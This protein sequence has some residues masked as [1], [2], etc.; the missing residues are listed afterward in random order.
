[1]TDY[2]SLIVSIMLVSAIM[3]MAYVGG[4]YIEDS[5]DF[6]TIEIQSNEQS[7]SWMLVKV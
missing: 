2:R 3:I 4:V 1:M 6:V 7:L 5:V